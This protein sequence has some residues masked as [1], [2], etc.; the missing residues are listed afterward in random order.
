MPVQQLMTAK[1]TTG[2]SSIAA[3]FGPDCTIQMKGRTTSGAGAAA[4]NIEVSNDEV[5]WV[6]GG[7]ISLTLG[8]TDTTDGVHIQASW[9]FVRLNVTS[10]SGTGASVDGYLGR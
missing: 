3:G 8:T 9:P 10:I 5:S 7:S 4:A 2:A 1:T 6:V